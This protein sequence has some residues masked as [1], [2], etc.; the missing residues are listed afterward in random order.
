MA[1]V[2]PKGFRYNVYKGRTY[3]QEQVYGE[4]KGHDLLE[5]KG[6]GK[7][8]ADVNRVTKSVK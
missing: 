3:K 5:S 6:V 8:R 4:I 7:S 1:L 2:G